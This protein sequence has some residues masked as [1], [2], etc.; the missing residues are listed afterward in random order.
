MILCACFFRLPRK[1][2]SVKI[3]YYAGN[4]RQAEDAGSGP[5]YS[6]SACIGTTGR[7]ACYIC[8][9]M[10]STSNYA[11]PYSVCPVVGLLGTAKECTEN[12]DPAQKY[13]HEMATEASCTLRCTTLLIFSRKLLFSCTSQQE[14]WIVPHH[15]MQIDSERIL[16]ERR[17]AQVQVQVRGDE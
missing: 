4:V 3:K 6:Y 13:M 1:E 12:V 14:L 10:P 7:L 16:F 17:K 15:Q 5:G 11:H 9:T 8:S 2:S